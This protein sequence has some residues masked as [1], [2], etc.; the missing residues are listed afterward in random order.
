[1]LG[2]IQVN[3]LS[4]KNREQTGEGS[5]QNSASANKRGGEGANFSY[6]W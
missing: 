3:S 6:L 5:Y 1:M 4:S 2:L